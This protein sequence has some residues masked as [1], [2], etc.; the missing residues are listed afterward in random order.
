VKPSALCGE[1]FKNSTT[2]STGFHRGKP[3]RKASEEAH[4]A[5]SR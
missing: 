4:P 5:S 1:V 3:Q 2:E